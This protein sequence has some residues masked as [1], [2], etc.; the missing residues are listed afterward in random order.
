MES[1][2][3]TIQ[4]ALGLES[5]EERSA[6]LDQVCA[7]NAQLRRRIERILAELDEC[8]DAPDHFS[9]TAPAHVE[10]VQSPRGNSQFIALLNE[11][12]KEVTEADEGIE[13]EGSVIGRYKL[14]QKIG[15]GGFGTVYMAEQI[16]P[17]SRRVALKIIKLGMDTKQV[18][19]RFEAERQALALMDD[20]NIAKVLDAGATD[21]GRPYFVMELVKGIP[22][23][24]FCN[25]RQ[26]DTRHRLDIF[27]DVCSALQHAHQKGIIHRDL[28]PS[29]ILVTLHG[30]KPVPKV[31]D[32]GIAKATQQAID[33]QDAVHPVRAV[34]WD[35]SLH[36]S[37][38]GCP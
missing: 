12:L 4:E 31:I 16:E 28:K 15:E 26:L 20:P 38:T 18:V 14:L 8:A 1:F 36:E 2:K 3:R 17:V 9:L 32:F 27:V 24:R 13:R 35:S 11:G 5:L 22:I 30:N 37:R 10:E 19:A 21:S 6:Y 23:T 7:G 25:E 33:R 34:H 29:N